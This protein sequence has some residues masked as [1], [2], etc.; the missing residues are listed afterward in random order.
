ML[1][2]FAEKSSVLLKYLKLLLYNK[3]YAIFCLLLRLKRTRIREICRRCLL[4]KK[5]NETI[6][7]TILVDYLN[8]IYYFCTEQ[9]NVCLWR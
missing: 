6:Y 2:V 1:I 3:V 9:I 5:H 4:L 8:I 7:S